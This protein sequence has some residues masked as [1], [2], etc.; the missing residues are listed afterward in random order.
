MFFNVMWAIAKN[1]GEKIW[2]DVMNCK[3]TGVEMDKIIKV[4][5]RGL[6]ASVAQMKDQQLGI[7]DDLACSMLGHPKPESRKRKKT[8][9]AGGGYLKSSKKRKTKKR[10]TKKRR[11]KRRRTKKRRKTKRRKK[12]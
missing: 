4:V 3:M 2:E 6:D 9:K 7:F 5:E 11:T 1:G 8:E 12:E 10:R